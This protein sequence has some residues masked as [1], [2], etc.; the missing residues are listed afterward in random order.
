[1]DTWNVVVVF[2]QRVHIFNADDTQS[3]QRETGSG[4]S[5]GRGTVEPNQEETEA[6]EETSGSSDKELESGEEELEEMVQP[7][8]GWYFLHSRTDL[9]RVVTLS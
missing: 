2:T 8:R 5:I 6:W 4:A 9:I 7:K 3:S 1:M